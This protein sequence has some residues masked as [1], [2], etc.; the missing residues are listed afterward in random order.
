MAAVSAAN[1]EWTLNK[2]EWR[3]PRGLA[4]YRAREQ[5]E[6]SLGRQLVGLLLA[7]LVV[8]GVGYAGLTVWRSWSGRGGALASGGASGPQPGAGGPT[9]ELEGLAGRLFGSIQSG[10]ADR[11]AGADPTPVKFEIKSGETAAQ[12][13]ENLQQQG[14]I[15]DATFFRLL[16]RLQG[17]DTKLEAGSYELKRTMSPREIA[18]ALQRG[19]PASVTVTIPEGW[20]AEEIAALLSG[21][22]LVDQAEFMR[23][24]QSGEGFT[25]PFLPPRQNGQANLN[26]YLFP[27][28]YTFETSASD[29][30]KVINRLLD[31]FGQKVGADLRA[32]AAS[33]EL[34]SLHA[35]VTLA[36]I[37]EREARIPEERPLIAGVYANRL[38]QGMKL[39]ADPTV[40]YAMGYDQARQTW[41]RPLTV[42]DYRFDA[43]WNTYVNRDLPPGPI[44]NPGLASLQAAAA[45]ASTDYLY[46]VA[47]RDGSH[48]FATTFEEHV[49]N[50]NAAK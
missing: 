31:N 20:R 42:E 35:V 13:A 25:Q 44:A 8:A 4:A 5:R 48:A 2:K 15:R 16:L 1:G 47:R 19:R 45:P 36:S 6:K 3:E 46:F 26:G 22:G 43:P 28:T 14:L 12:I 41:W 49:R 10:E 38:R 34:G 17:I 50:V 11:P 29:A 37:V 32:K 33:S 9:S 7:I 23:L 30:R 21:Y 40:Q 39:D 18:V 27:D 24:V